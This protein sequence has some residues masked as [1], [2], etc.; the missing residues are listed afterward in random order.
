VD[1]IRTVGLDRVISLESISKVRSEIRIEGTCDNCRDERCHS[2]LYYSLSYLIQTS[3]IGRF[4][5]II[6]GE[7]ETIST[8]YLDI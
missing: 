3:F 8:V 7:V 2:C 4:V 6:N 1:L 5:P